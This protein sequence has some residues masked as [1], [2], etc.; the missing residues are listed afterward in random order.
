MA[1]KKTITREHIL[2]ATYQVV[3]TEGF[4]GFTARNIASKMRSSTQPIYLEFK[5]MED[6][7]NAFFR[8]VE[9]DLEKDIFSKVVTGDALVDLCLNYVDFAREQKMLY[10]ALFVEDFDGGENLTQFL[11]QLISDKM[12]TDDKYKSLSDTKKE[13]LLVN[14]WIVATG[15]AS[16]VSADRIQPTQ[17]EIA[18]LVS[19]SVEF[20]MN[21]DIKLSVT[22]PPIV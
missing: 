13:S 7:R 12:K 8:E 2:D 11:H 9:S 22:M 19:N 4:S 5:N 17:T 1:R 14:F 16:L 18:T 6:L 3:A 20:S 10:R 15:L 21:S